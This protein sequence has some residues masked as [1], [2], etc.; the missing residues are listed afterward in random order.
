MMAARLVRFPP[1]YDSEA[2][3]SRAFKRVIGVPPSHYR[4]VD[5]APGLSVGDR[6]LNP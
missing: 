5:E 1:D 4:G 6:S 3:F 2:A